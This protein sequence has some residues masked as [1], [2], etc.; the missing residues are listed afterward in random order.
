MFR[1]F[2][3]IVRGMTIKENWFTLIVD[4]KI[5]FTVDVPSKLRACAAAQRHESQFPA[6]FYRFSMK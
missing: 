2:Y 3:V 1:P 6:H 5:W 4:L